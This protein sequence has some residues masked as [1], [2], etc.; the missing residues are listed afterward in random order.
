MIDKLLSTKAIVKV[1]PVEG[2]HISRILLVPKKEKDSFRMVI[3]LK[4]LNK[5]VICPSFKWKSIGQL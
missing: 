1:S 4:G 5:N 2:Q 3:N